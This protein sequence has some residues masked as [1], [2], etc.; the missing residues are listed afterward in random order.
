MLG[1][2]NLLKMSHWISNDTFNCFQNTLFALITPSSKF[3][4]KHQTIIHHQHQNLHECTSLEHTFIINKLYAS[5][6]QHS[7][8][9]FLHITFKSHKSNH[10]VVDPVRDYQHFT[11]N[12]CDFNLQ[13]QEFKWHDSC[14]NFWSS[15]T[16]QGL[17]EILFFV[18]QN[19]KP[20]N[21]CALCGFYSK[22]KRLSLLPE[23]TVFT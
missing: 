17:E 20:Q 14:I 15:N 5:G 1:W 4:F 21:V 7:T 19:K 9:I 3:F 22:T 10:F 12:E 18:T 6:I 8:S 11:L 16:D 2:P 23:I 13:S